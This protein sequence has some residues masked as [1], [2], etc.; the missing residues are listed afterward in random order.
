MQTRS[1]GASETLYTEVPA[2]ETGLDYVSVLEP[3][4]PKAFLYRSGMACSGLAIGDVD[5]DGWPDLFFAGGAGANHL[6]RQV[7]SENG[8]LR[9]ED[10]T[11]RAGPLDGGEHWSVG[12]SMIDIDNDSDLDIYVCNYDAPN[13]L[14]VNEGLAEDGVVRFVERAEAFGLAIS[15]ASHMPAFCDYDNDGDLDLYLQTGRL[16]D[17]R[18]YKGNDA[19]TLV[20]GRPVLKPGYEKHYKLWY[21]DED[22]WGVR[23][24]GREDYLLRNDGGTFTDVSADAGIGGRGD[25]LSVT[26]WDSNADGWMDLY[27]GNDMI[28][29]DRFYLNQGD[30]TFRNVIDERIPH[31]SWFSMG[32]DFGDLNNDGHADFL[33]ADMSATNHFKQK[34]TMG[35]MGGPILEAANSSRPP[36]LMR[37]ALYIGTGTERFLEG[38][39]L[40][41]LDSTDWTWAVKIAD[42]D[43]DGWQDVFVT[44]GTARAMND[45]D[46]TF[47]AEQ[48]REAPEWEYL[49][50]LPR[51][52]E[53]N[54]AVRNTG[55]GFHFEDVSAAW[56]LG[57]VGVSYGA[58]YGDLDRDGDLDLVVT[59]VEDTV[60]LYRN[61]ASA[62]NRILLELAGKEANPSGLGARVEIMAGGVRQQ[63]QLVAES[64]Y[65]SANDPL[66]HFGLGEAAQIDRLTV[67]WPGGDS[68]S[69]T[70]LEA[71]RYYLITQASDGKSHQAPSHPSPF[72]AEIDLPLRK[73][74]EVPFDDFSLQLLLPNKLSELGAGTAWGDV[75]GDGDDDLYLGGAAGQIGEL[76][77]NQGDGRF[78]QRWVEAFR[79]DKACEDMGTVFFDADGDR[80]QDLYVVSGS[81]Q[82]EQDSPAL[83]D[84]L[85]LNDG[86]GNFTSAPEGALPALRESGS[87]VTAADYDRDGDLD[88]FVGGRVIPGEYPLSPRSALLRNDGGVFADVAAE[89][90]G[91]AKAGL[92]TSALWSD[93]NGDGWLDLFVTTE[94]GPVRLFTNAA[95]RLS[96]ATQATGLGERLGWWNSIAGGDIDG[97]GDIDYAV[98]NQ[99]ENTK[100]HASA[101]KPVQIYYGDYNGD[102]EMNLVEAEFEEDVLYPVRGKSCSSNAMP[103]LKEKFTTF[104]QFA[105]ASLEDIY[106]E[107]SLQEAHQFEVNTLDSGLFLNDGNG[108][109]TWRPFP[110][111]VQISPVFGL[112]FVDADADGHLDLYVTQ[113]FFAP[114]AETGRFDSGL[115][116]L[117]RGDGT[118]T[119]TP[120]WPAESGL[121]VPGDAT[122]LT[123]SDLNADQRPD[124][125]VQTN[126]GYPSVFLNQSAKTFLAVR[127]VGDSAGARVTLVDSLGRSQVRE[128]YAGGGYLSQSSATL[129]FGTGTAQPERIVVNWPD[130]S[131][132]VVSDLNESTGSL[133]LINKE[134]AP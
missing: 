71:N 130:G 108:S 40:S 132:V 128:I 58:A 122:S 90:E 14:F 30:G 52:E 62:A 59:N 70:N 37:N 104:R 15:D 129:F 34:T 125:L 35:V 126:N 100:Y 25:G 47:T 39:Y 24:Y 13:E 117:L 31:T 78:E 94:W 102:G 84:R 81:Y 36:Q 133:V 3:D 89:V 134:D 67:H 99:G 98:G 6:Y 55:H 97:D 5:D 69:F 91:L 93:A 20:D 57:K 87:V 28:S 76:R 88:L 27:V 103:H 119:L 1:Q 107:E 75:D 85:Y 18:G 109:F 60:S 49:K 48:L 115:S 46:Y 17:P 112:A 50:D 56:G 51:R 21:E 66:L 68:Q 105:A 7:A 120:V 96:E 29:P 73:H 54:R 26:W 79:G 80:D 23:A 110:E 123:V 116:M 45:S 61:D 92:V 64:G 111:I 41:G 65:L 2:S 4:H 118:G 38:A 32:A 77:I 11:S 114:Q 124:F 82:F 95:G 33:I 16:E 86:S 131:E 19:Y 127:P 42:L 8:G 44:N 106:S 83:Q 10:I 101:E 72:F 113:N 53:M 74:R 43:N 22:N 63:R 9:F 121:L 12:V